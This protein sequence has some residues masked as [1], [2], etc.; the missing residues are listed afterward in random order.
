[1]PN[2]HRVHAEGATY[3]FTVVTA[4]R[5]PILQGKHAELLL[6]I[7]GEIR[8]ETPFHSEAF[9]I[10]PDHLH[11]IWRLPDGDTD[12]SKRWGLIK[13]RFSKR[14]GL[15]SISSHGQDSGIWQPRFWEHLIRS[16]HDWRTHMDYV[17]FNPI[18][19]GLVKR[20]V[21]WPYSSFH[22]WVKE[23]FYAP[24]WGVAQD[25]FTRSNFGE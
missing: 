13:S 5:K 17:H 8:Q 24:D 21:E 1:M 25:A 22:Q 9:V 6:E 12:Y 11:A 23:G 10:L 15:P 3:F 4:Q 2:Y 18:K 19:H 14:C 16:D 7:M 20:V